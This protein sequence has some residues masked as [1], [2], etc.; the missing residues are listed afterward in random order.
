MNLPEEDIGIKKEFLKELMLEY[1]VDTIVDYY[2]NI[3]I[4]DYIDRKEKEFYKW[5]SKRQK[6]AGED[7]Q[8]NWWHNF[9]KCLKYGA[10]TQIPYYSDKKIDRAAKSKY[11]PGEKI[12]DTWVMEPE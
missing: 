6:E 8:P 11:S 9:L 5:R 2:R 4:E 10:G 3:T 1:V 7:G 12:D